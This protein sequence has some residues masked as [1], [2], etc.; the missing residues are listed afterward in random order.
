MAT[1]KFRKARRRN[2]KIRKETTTQRSALVEDDSNVSN[3][4]MAQI[5]EE[6]KLRCRKVGIQSSALMC[7]AKDKNIEDDVE[8]E[9]ESFIETGGLLEGGDVNNKKNLE[10]LLSGAFSAQT[11]VESKVTNA[12][13]ENYIKEKMGQGKTVE[14]VVEPKAEDL[15]Y[16]MPAHLAKEKKEE[17]YTT[18]GGP[19][20]FGTGIAEVEL[21]IE[22]KLKN[23]EDTEHA[24]QM[25]IHKREQRN[26]K[27][28]TA[29]LNKAVNN[30]K[31]DFKELN[32]ARD[33]APVGN[34]NSNF[35]HHQ[36]SFAQRMRHQ[37]AQSGRGGGGGGR[38]GRGRGN[39]SD[40]RCAARF[41]RRVQ[42]QR[43]R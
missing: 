22:F 16:A 23:I 18:D 26:K 38:G 29:E 30:R 41:R 32:E 25:L 7:K 4:A 3:D 17:V 10:G 39:G 24:K 5:K 31:R 9:I 13:L 21:P 1:V 37:R 11:N 15:V 34:H 6:Q 8:E 20:S 14:E 28:D 35:R 2:K 43:R 27:L 40:D 42:N 19:I 33:A 36:R 12:Q